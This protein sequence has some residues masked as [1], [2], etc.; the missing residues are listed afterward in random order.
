M[1]A[2]KSWQRFCS[3]TRPRVP[4]DSFDRLPTCIPD[5]PTTKLQTK[6]KKYGTRIIFFAKLPH[7]CQTKLEDIGLRVDCLNVRC[8]GLWSFND[9]EVSFLESEGFVGVKLVEK[10]ND[11]LRWRP[12]RRRRSSTTGERGTKKTKE[13]TYPRDHGS[14]RTRLIAYPPASQISQSLKPKPNWKSAGTESF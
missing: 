2:M 5:F 7:M 4:R 3:E 10:A 14:P 6:V 12:R 13:R 8:L 1:L 11:I 9:G